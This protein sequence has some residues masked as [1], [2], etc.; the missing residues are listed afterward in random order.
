MLGVA[1]FGLGCGGDTPEDGNGIAPPEPPAIS[2]RQIPPSAYFKL[3]GDLLEPLEVEPELSTFPEH[4]DV[5]GFDNNEAVS[6]ANAPT[7]DALFVTARAIALEARLHFSEMT[8]CADG[9]S[10]CAAEW[11]EGVLLRS[12]WRS[13][14][15]AADILADFA[16]DADDM[17]TGRALEAALH[18]VLMSPDLL[19]VPRSA[20]PNSV[21]E[22]L[23][24]RALA[25]KLADFLWMGVPDAELVQAA[26]N[27]D[28]DT[29]AGVEGQVDRMLADPRAERAVL[30]FYGQL[31]E[32]DRVGRA[33]PDIDVVFPGVLAEAA[34]SLIHLRLQPS[35]V[36]EAELFVG[37]HIFAGDARLATLLTSNHSFPSVEL[38]EEVY[39]QP[40]EQGEVVESGVAASGRPLEY[41]EAWF[42]PAERSGLLTLV[43]FLHGASLP[44]NG[45][46][47]QRG[48]L[49]LERLLCST[50]PPPP[51]DVPSLPD[52]DRAD[53]ITNRDRYAAYTDRAGCRG[54]HRPID[55]IGFAFE[56]Y[57]LMGR[58][59]LED[60]GVPVDS[61]GE[62][63]GTDVDQAL[64][65][66]IELTTIL[67]ESRVVADCHVLNWFRYAM[68]R[69]ETSHD[70]ET[71][72]WLRDGFSATD[73]DVLELIRTIAL[74]DEFA[75]V[76]VTP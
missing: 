14:G 20:E 7:T 28:L 33:E 44:Q 66:A 8:A 45:S 71:I 52:P 22:R 53:P 12:H 55:G 9:D 21:T 31:L 56:N 69:T 76:T 70:S 34:A 18:R 29:A 61:S 35:M 72:E 67:A 68:G 75:Q 65:D 11:L 2:V 50:P 13:P 25:R 42:D 48:V 59:R 64:S 57:D 1:A 40:L 62:L 5:H 46:P 17:E 51:P 73:G 15:T 37:H 27:G 4:T 10:D 63:L 58:Y 47:V 74:S 16:R 60:N 24:A 49:I 30:N 38:V 32:W 3:V 26:M 36:R 39:G 41:R 23:P 19:Y 54:C 43:A 6:A